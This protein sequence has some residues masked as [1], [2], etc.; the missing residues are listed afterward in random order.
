[1]LNIA[2]KSLLVHDLAPNAKQRPVK[3]HSVRIIPLF[4]GSRIWHKWERA[5]YLSFQFGWQL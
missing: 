1:M 5:F 3:T 4:T 2:L